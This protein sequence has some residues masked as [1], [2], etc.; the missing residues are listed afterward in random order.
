MR[1]YLYHLKQ[2]GYMPEIL[3]TDRG[4]ETPMLADAHYGL[5]AQND[6]LRDRERSSAIPYRNHG[7]DGDEEIGLEH[8]YYFGK[9]T[10]NL[11]V[12]TWWGQLI[13]SKI[14]PWLVSG[15]WILCC[16]TDG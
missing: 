1:Q 6:Y 11:A 7:A 2:L 15:K 12:E 13:R 5:R 8:C 16:N 3:R 9:S 4:S 14:K 10:R